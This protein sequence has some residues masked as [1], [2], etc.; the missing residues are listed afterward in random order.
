MP[1]MCTGLSARYRSRD[2]G[3]QWTFYGQA[4]GHIHCKSGQKLV[5]QFAGHFLSTFVCIPAKILVYICG[6]GCPRSGRLVHPQVDTERTNVWTE[7]VQRMTR[8]PHCQAYSNPTWGT[9]P[10]CGQ[11]LRAAAATPDPEPLTQY[12]PCVVCEE[13][14]GRWNDRGIWRCR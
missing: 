5:Y 3:T 2:F 14:T 9:C 7:E 6:Q 12:Y 8:C 11:L 4:C 13:D 1:A 10:V